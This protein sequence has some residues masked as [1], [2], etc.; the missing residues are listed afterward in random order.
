MARPALTK[1]KAILSSSTKIM[2]PSGEKPD[3]YE[4]GISQAL[5]DLEMNLD[6]QAQ[7]RELKITANETIVGSSWKAIIILFLFLN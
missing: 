6:L 5:L 1:E 4:S 7:L 2:K 3:R